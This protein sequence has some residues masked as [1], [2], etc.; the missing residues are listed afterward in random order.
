MTT[1]K[2]KPKVILSDPFP[3]RAHV[4]LACKDCAKSGL[5]GI[6]TGF[7]HGERGGV[8]DLVWQE[9]WEGKTIDVKTTSGQV[10]TYTISEPLDRLPLSSLEQVPITTM[11]ISDYI[12]MYGDTTEGY[13]EYVSYCGRKNLQAIT[14]HGSPLANPFTLKDCEAALFNL[15]GR[16]PSKER[17]LRLACT[18]FSDALRITLKINL[19]HTYEW[20]GHNIPC[21]NLAGSEQRL[22]SKI[23]EDLMKRDYPGREISP[24]A[25][26]ARQAEYER[27]LT[28]ELRDVEA[29]FFNL[30][31]KRINHKAM[32]V[33]LKRL[34]QVYRSGRPMILLCWCHGHCHTYS[35]AR[36]IEYLAGTEI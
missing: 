3:L 13:H 23:V 35:I 30:Y 11:H 21:S 12:E 32:W 2:A 27:S 24:E 10:P 34:V 5:H 25:V 4:R 31:L 1:T 19:N 29:G 9:L 33:E 26:Q 6:I 17:T 8:V 20:R 14:E 7:P 18:R 15:E 28:R 36:A 16:K 22:T